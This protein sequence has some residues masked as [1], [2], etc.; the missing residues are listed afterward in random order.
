MMTCNRFYYYFILNAYLPTRI[1]GILV[2]YF[3]Y[4]NDHN[5]RVMAY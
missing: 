5:L 2:L 1:V 3:Y 4:M